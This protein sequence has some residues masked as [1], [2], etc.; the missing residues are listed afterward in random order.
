ML[1]LTRKSLVWIFTVLFAFLA[2]MGEGLHFLPGMGH[3]C[4]DCYVCS[5]ESQAADHECCQWHHVALIRTGVQATDVHNPSDC[6][7]CK[8]F[9]QIKPYFAPACVTVEHSPVAQR[10]TVLV[11]LLEGRTVSPYQPRGPPCFP[12][13]S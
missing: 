10:F 12:Q 6:P 7:I 8:Y 4:C 3:S 11:S 13:N 9:S 2:T 1:A 5:H